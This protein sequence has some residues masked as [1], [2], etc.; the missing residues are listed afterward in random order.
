MRICDEIR[1]GVNQFHFS[2]SLSSST[3][4]NESN[5][6][7]SAPSDPIEGGVEGESHLGS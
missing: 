5:Q 7:S 1:I 3:M 2:V 6:F 4:G